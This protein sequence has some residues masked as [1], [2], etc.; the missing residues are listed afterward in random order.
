MQHII[1]GLGWFVT[2]WFALVVVLLSF[3]LIIFVHELG[4]FLTAKRV[5]ITVHEFALGFGPKLFSR[6]HD[7]TEYCLRAF[8]FGGFVRMEGED[9]PEGNPDDPGSFLN[10]SVTAQIVVLGGGCFMNYVSALAVLLLLGFAHGAIPNPDHMMVP[11]NIVGGVQSDSP[12]AR[13]GLKEG[14][15]I[16]AVNDTP[17]ATFIDVVNQVRGHGGEEI[18]ISVTR[19]GQPMDFRL[20]PNVVDDGSTEHR[21]V[22]RMGVIPTSKGTIAWLPVSGA[23]E[24]FNRSGEWIVKITLLPMEIVQRLVRKETTLKE[25]GEGTGGPLLI[26]QMLFEIYHQGVWPLLFFWAIIC[27]SVGSFNLL[28]IPALDGARILFVG[29]GALR[30]RPLDPRKEGMVHM[31]GLAVLLVAMAAFSVHDVVRMVKGVKFF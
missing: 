19:D 24:V 30:G 22:G 2:N 21:K 7:G 27:V 17:V 4:H 16:V 8:P 28:P 15:H 5:G 29:I 31:V 20:T 6:V 12:A 25:V 9:D 3:G 26:G 10:K 23:G 14:D 18:K 13:A 11:L 1:D